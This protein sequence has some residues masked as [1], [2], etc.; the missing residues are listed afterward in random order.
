MPSRL[1][2]TCS[3]G[4][5][6]YDMPELERLPNP[7]QERCQQGSQILG[8]PSSGRPRGVRRCSV[9]CV[10]LAC[11]PCFSISR[12]HGR[13]V[14]QRRLSVADRCRE[15]SQLCARRSG[16]FSHSRVRGRLL[17]KCLNDL[18]H[19]YRR[20]KGTMII[21]DRICMA[22]SRLSRSDLHGRWRSERG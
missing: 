7:L 13:Q 5:D 9:S 17:P 12:S 8:T 16:H 3:R 19:Q 22:Y 20:S 4:A 11:G 15:Y 18:A 10:G 2:R 14:I 1:S 6:F 21:V